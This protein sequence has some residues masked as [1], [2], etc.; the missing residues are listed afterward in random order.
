M[1]DLVDL[2]FLAVTG[3]VG[4]HALTW[5]DAEGRRDWVRQLFGCIAVLFFVRVLLVDVFGV[6]EPAHLW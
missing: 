5:R 4:W 2:L 3:V 1:P 6:L